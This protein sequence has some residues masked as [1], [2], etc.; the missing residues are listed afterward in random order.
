MIR[1]V[2]SIL[3]EVHWAN[4]GDSYERL[5]QSPTSNYLWLGSPSPGY[6]SVLPYHLP[7]VGLEC[8]YRGAGMVDRPEQPHAGLIIKGRDMLLRKIEE[9]PASK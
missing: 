5:A 3:V 1:V 4:G 2:D 7:C 6:T 8:D 9:R